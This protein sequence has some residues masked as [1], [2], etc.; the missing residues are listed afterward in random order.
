M[1]DRLA[2][3][4][5]DQLFRSARSRNGWAPKP[6]SEANPG[7]AGNNDPGRPARP[8]PFCRCDIFSRDER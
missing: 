7:A 5:L 6:L 4:S 1:T 3:A 8:Q 2:D